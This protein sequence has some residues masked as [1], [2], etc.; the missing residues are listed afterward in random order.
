MLRILLSYFVFFEMCRK[1]VT[2]LYLIELLH[3]NMILVL[4]YNNMWNNK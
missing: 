3:E 4:K 1:Y 2:M